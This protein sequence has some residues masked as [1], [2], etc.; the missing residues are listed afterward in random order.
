MSEGIAT[1]AGGLAGQERASREGKTASGICLTYGGFEL[2]NVGLEACQT[3]LG[4][5]DPSNQQWFTPDPSASPT[6]NSGTI[7]IRSSPKRC[8]NSA[9]TASTNSSVAVD[10]A[11]TADTCQEAQRKAGKCGAQCGG[12]LNTTT[13]SLVSVPSARLRIGSVGG[14]AQPVQLRS[15]VG[16]FT[17]CVTVAPTGPPVHDYIN[18]SLQ[19]WAKRLG[20]SAPTGTGTHGLAHN[21]ALGTGSAADA[22]LARNDDASPIAVVV[23]NRGPTSVANFNVTWAMLGLSDSVQ[24]TVRDLWAHADRGVHQGAFACKSIPSHDVCT[25]LITPTSR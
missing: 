22:S 21:I 6:G 20:G 23:F 16:N 17:R 7:T 5:K 14:A 1:E 2:S 12:G 9:C 15:A 11:I 24:A 4:S 19:V 10:M 3:P 8:L 18:I 25:L 13:F